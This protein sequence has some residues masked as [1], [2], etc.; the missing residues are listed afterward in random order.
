MLGALSQIQEGYVLPAILNKEDD[1]GCWVG[2]VKGEELVSVNH[3]HHVGLNLLDGDILV[4]VRLF[5]QYNAPEYLVVVGRMTNKKS[6]SEL[7]LPQ[8]AHWIY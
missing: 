8:G 2:G 6:L 1:I 5:A 3:L 7:G 4:R